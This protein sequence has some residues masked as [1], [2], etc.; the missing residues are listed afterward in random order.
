MAARA[1][2]NAGLAML[3]QGHPREALKMLQFAQVKAWG[4][5]PEHDRRMVESCAQADS[6]TALLGIG[7]AQTAV[8]ELAK[9]RDL[10]QPTRTDPRGDHDY[11]SARLEV[12]RGRLDAAAP[13]AVASAARWDGVSELR[14][15][16]S[17]VVLA[18]VHVQAGE[19][20]GPA[21]AHRA[22]TDVTKLSSVQA[23][24]RLQPL[25]EALQS[26]PGGDAKELARMARQVATTRV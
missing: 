22:I 10:W 12:G 16:Y 4:I 7:A 8:T 21:M 24:T 14:R 23:R 19:P 20:D 17:A 3:A 2:L 11:V 9:S 13:F 25:V 5:P 6:V 1:A 18:T 26:R 15:T